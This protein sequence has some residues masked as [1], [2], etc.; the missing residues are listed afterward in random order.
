MY[1]KCRAGL[2]T[3]CTRC[4]HAVTTRQRNNTSVARYKNAKCLSFRVKIE[5]RNTSQATVVW[6]LNNVR[7]S[8]IEQQHYVNKVK[9]PDTET[10]KYRPGGDVLFFCGVIQ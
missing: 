8:L 2:A 4:D 5:F 1:I 9:I 7:L 10:G 6:S 3:T